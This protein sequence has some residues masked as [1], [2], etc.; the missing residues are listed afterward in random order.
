[1]RARVSRVTLSVHR[2]YMAVFRFLGPLFSM[3]HSSGIPLVAR[4]V[5]L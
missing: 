3:L 2:V 5:R 1:M 4:G